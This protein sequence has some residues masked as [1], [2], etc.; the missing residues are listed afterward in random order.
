MELSQEN[1][2]YTEGYENVH[3]I[4][5]LNLPD[6]TEL[7]CVRSK[8]QPNALLYYCEPAKKH[9]AGCLN[10]GSVNYYIHGYIKD[11]FVHDISM[12][13]IHVDLLLKTPRYKCNDCGVTFVHQFE[14]VAGSTQFTKRLYDQIKLRAL[15]GAF[16]PI[17]KEF[18]TSPATIATIFSEYAHELA[19]GRTLVAPRVL[20]IDEKHIVHKMRGV[21]VDI[22]EGRLIEMTEKN[23]FE[24]VIQTIESFEGYDTNIKIVTID[25]CTAYVKAVSICLPRAKIVID[26]YH[27]I[28]LLYRKATSCRIKVTEYLKN[29]TSNM[30]DS[31]EKTYRKKLLTKLGKNVY[32]FKFGNKKLAEKPERIQ[33]MV[34]LCETFPELNTLRLLKIGAERIYNAQS[35]E[36]A[37]GY[38]AEWKKLIPKSEL[39]ADL[40]SFQRTMETWKI[41]IFNYFDPDSRYTNAATEGINNLIESMNR[42]GRG[43][44]F[45]V[46]RTKALYHRSASVLPVYEKKK[47]KL[48]DFK[49]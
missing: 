44:S 11:R 30:V 42:V 22:T 45:D 25:M 9:R 47:N 40:R 49:K 21:F 32:L 23:D 41:Y 12:G 4:P 43:Y 2:H 26:K 38:Y 6:L 1:N 18:G 29:Q 28:Q 39:F 34:D 13:I 27:V 7:Q 35:R 14:S 37:E 15:D 20:G 17:A 5:I 24:T 19:V 16:E 31:D 46:L 10:C 36:E 33:L 8:G 48:F 3:P